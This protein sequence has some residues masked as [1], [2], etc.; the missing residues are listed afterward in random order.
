[1][2]CTLPASVKLQLKLPVVASAD[3]KALA[4]LRKIGVLAMPIAQNT[5]AIANASYAGKVFDDQKL[6][7]SS[8]SPN[9]YFCLTSLVPVSRTKE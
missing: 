8:H 2:P 7:F 6:D 4:D 3:P 1:M 9:N 5:N